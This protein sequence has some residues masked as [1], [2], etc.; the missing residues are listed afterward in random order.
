MFAAPLFGSSRLSRQPIPGAGPHLFFAKVVDHAQHVDEAQR[1][2]RYVV[3]AY[4]EAE[5][6]RLICEARM[7]PCLVELE[8]RDSMIDEATKLFELQYG[9]ACCVW[10]RDEC[11]AQCADDYLF[12]DEPR[13]E[14][15]VK[16]LGVMRGGEQHIATL[17]DLL[18]CQKQ[19]AKDV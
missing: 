16:I 7:S 1:E 14:T 17:Q 18:A 5:A 12:I 6:S 19:V 11:S 4:S 13:D 3:I 2:T 15:D 9:V 8:M 10:P